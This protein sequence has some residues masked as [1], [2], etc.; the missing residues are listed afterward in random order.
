[1]SYQSTTAANRMRLASAAARLTTLS[2]PARNGLSGTGTQGHT[3]TA[4]A[5]AATE[6]YEALTV[7]GIGL[8]AGSVIV[9]HGVRYSGVTLSGT[10][11]NITATVSNNRITHILRDAFF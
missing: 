4:L 9:R 11:N 6:M 2:A 10:G 7:C 1:M 8:P 5:E 3:D